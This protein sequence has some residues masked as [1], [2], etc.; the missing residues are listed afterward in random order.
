MDTISSTRQWQISEPTPFSKKKTVLLLRTVVVISTGYLILFGQ[1]ANEPWALGYI[2]AL[3]FTN[4][5]LGLTPESWFHQTRF[6]ALLLLGD[7]AAVLIGLYLTV[8]CFSQDFLIIYFFT[9][10]LTTATEGVA[11]IAVGAAMV[12][13]LYGYWLWLSATHALGAGEWL[14]LPFFFIVAVFYAYMTEETKVE[15]WRRKQAERER[16]R[17]R[18]LLDLS[19]PLALRGAGRELITEVTTAI[20]SAFPRLECSVAAAAPTN[21]VPGGRWFPIHG[22]EP[23]LGGV[24]VL[25]RDEMPL[26]ADEDQFCKVVASVAGHA[27]AAARA[28]NSDEN[29]RLRQEFLGML[30]HELRTP[31]HAILG[32]AEMIAMLL[33][34][35]PDRRTFDALDRLQANATHLQ[36]LVGQMLWLAELR[37][38]DRALDRGDVA[39]QEVLDEQWRSTQPQLAGRVIDFS[40]YVAP[41]TPTLHTDRAKLAQIIGCL[42]NNAVKFTERGFI[43]VEA[44]PLDDEFVEIAVSDSGVGIA[45]EHM[46]FIFEAFRQG[47]SSMTRRAGGLGLGLAL[48]REL[49]VLLGG[50][51]AFE[52]QSKRGTTFRLRV[53]V[54]ARSAVA[55]QSPSRLAAACV[56]GAIQSLR[57]A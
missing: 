21:L 10:F 46:G 25:P 29:A 54:G 22:R 28:K 7:T 51:I 57:L 50:D 16:S 52:S 34:A 4:L 12:S 43:R 19:E 1:A 40:T 18:F 48:A 47:D 30:S 53:P 39:L 11:Q 45:A 41:G 55:E 27:L 36:G 9:I 14:R 8:G 3:L 37:S 44:R 56:Q 33:S 35:P 5:L 42:V 20:E 32:Y 38:G 6:S 24:L 17:L 23:K 13:G 49:A 15:R 2:A 31:L 26:T